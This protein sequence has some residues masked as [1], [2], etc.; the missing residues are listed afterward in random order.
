MH[1]RVIHNLTMEKETPKKKVMKSYRLRPEIVE[2]I[3]K[4]MER[5]GFTEETA[6]VETVLQLALNVNLP[7]PTRPSVNRKAL[8]LAA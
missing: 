8:A 5:H 1:Y 4:G 2:A 7:V 3:A 6:Y